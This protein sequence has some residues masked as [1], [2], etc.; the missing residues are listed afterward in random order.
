M[1]QEDTVGFL[2]APFFSAL[3]FFEHEVF[4]LRE[5]P[6]S[7]ERD[8]SVHGKVL[9]TCLSCSLSVSRDHS[10]KSS[11]HFLEA[12]SMRSWFTDSINMQMMLIDPRSLLKRIFFFF[13]F[14]MRCPK[15][16][17]AGMIVVQILN[18][19]LEPAGICGFRFPLVEHPSTFWT[20]ED[21]VSWSKA[22][23]VVADD[24]GVLEVSFVASMRLHCNRQLVHHNHESD[25]AVIR[26]WCIF[27]TGVICRT[28]LPATASRSHLD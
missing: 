13:F 6:L 24:R 22:S 5:Y 11:M 14:W 10:Y 3:F 15:T 27:S 12:Q 1:S 2:L 28:T 7:I 16:V 26:L 21:P 25:A 19:L 20:D 8:C 18:T 4:L 23:C 17:V 9:A